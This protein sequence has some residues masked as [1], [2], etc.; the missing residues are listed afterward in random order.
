MGIK[1][2]LAD[3]LLKWV[4][5][6]KISPIGW[7]DGYKTLIGNVLTVASAVLLVGIEQLTAIGVCPAWQ[8]CAFLTSTNAFIILLL[9]LLTKLVGEWHKKVKQLEG[10]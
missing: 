7:L 8:Y 5:E 6:S 1:T 2:F 4:L 3:K 10:K 9:S